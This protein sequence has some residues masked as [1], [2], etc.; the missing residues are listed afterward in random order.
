MNQNRRFPPLRK[1]QGWGTRAWSIL[2]VLILTA[3]ICSAQSTSPV[4]EAPNPPNAPAQQ[5][6][7]YVVLVSLDGF[8]YDYATKYGANNLLAMAKRGASAPDGM[9]PSFPS[10]TFPN[11]FSIVTGLYPDHH[12]IVGNTFYDPARKETYSLNNPKTTGDGSW[13]TGTPLWVL[14]EKQGMRAAC[15]Y[16]PSSDAEIQGKRPSYYPAAYDDKFADEKRVEQVLAWLQLPPEKRPHFITLYFEKTDDAGHT[17]GPDAAETGDAVRHVDDMVGKLSDGIAASGL[18]VDLIVVA[19]H[20]METLQGGWVVLDKWADLSQF[21]TS[22]SR[23][24]PK[25]EVDAEKAYQSLLGASDKFKVYRR[26]QAPAYLHF[27][28]NPR[29]GDPVVVPTG[30]YSIVAHDPNSKGAARMPPRGGHGYD[31]R[32][33]PSMKAIFFASGP[34]IRPGVTVASFENV[35]LYPLI[36]EIL[37]LHT[38]PIDG[39][40]RALQGILKKNSKN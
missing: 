40:L 22:G 32:Q 36:A 2:L 30:P 17:Y 29:E 9:I 37:G 4:I 15:F 20:G 35:D 19:D 33:M 24:Y 18:P 23:L 10:V 25:S 11:H 5:A 31:P 39:K 34:D 7:H 3:P 27:N 13:Y 28:S 14:A 12:G 6:K 26:A 38:G 8:R 1:P 16:W 21:E